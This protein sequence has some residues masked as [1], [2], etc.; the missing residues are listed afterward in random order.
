MVKFADYSNGTL[1][2]SHT[3][4]HGFWWIGGYPT[5]SSLALQSFS[6]LV[7]NCLVAVE[8]S[9]RVLFHIY[10]TLDD[11]DVVNERTAGTR[12]CMWL[13]HLKLISRL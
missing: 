9:D 10:K 8:F 12:L 3:F 13:A 5:A 1:A 6:L 11:R 7:L 2:G 4:M